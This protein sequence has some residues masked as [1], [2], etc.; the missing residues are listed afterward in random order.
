[1]ADEKLQTVTI[2]G[3]EYALDTLSDE[4]KAKITNVRFVDAEIARLRNQLVLCQA[5]RAEFSRRLLDDLP[6]G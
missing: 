1:M 4:V 2:D 3:K 6:P 5:A